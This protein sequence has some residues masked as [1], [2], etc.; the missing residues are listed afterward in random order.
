MPYLGAFVCRQ[1]CCLHDINYFPI[2]YD[3]VIQ[4]ASCPSERIN[5]D[6]SPFSVADQHRDRQRSG[7]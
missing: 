4:S 2:D 5:H 3:H 7:V 1:A 6:G